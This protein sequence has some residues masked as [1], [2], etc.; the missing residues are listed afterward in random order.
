MAPE[1]LDA[2]QSK[3]SK[4]SKELKEKTDIP[5]IKGMP[6]FI[7]NTTSHDNSFQES[8]ED[9]QEIW[10]DVKDLIQ[11]FYCSDCDK[12]LSLKLYDNVERKIRCSCGNLKY[13]WK[14]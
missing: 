1:L 12:F 8:I 14:K 7:G 3:L 4:K 5:K 11:N 13:D 6:M 2:V 9:L 10:E